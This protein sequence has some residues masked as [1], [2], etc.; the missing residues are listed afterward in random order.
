MDVLNKVISNKNKLADKMVRNMNVEIA[1]LG[2]CA[3]SITFGNK[4]DEGIHQQIH[5]FLHIFRLKRVKGVIEYAPSYTSIAIFYNPAIV[6][7]SQLV[8]E[9]YSSYHSAL[10]TTEIQSIVYRIPVYYGGKTGPDLRFVAE[11]HNINEQEVINLHA[12]KE[13]LIHMI[14]FVPGFPYLGGLSKKIAT[15]RLEKPRPKIAA[16]SVGIGGSQTGIYPSEV[17]SGW[18]IIGITPLSLFDL[19]NENPSLLSAGN[20]VSFQPIEYE[21]FLTIQAQVA[22]K[23]YDIKTYKRER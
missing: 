2:D 1:P 17:P 19:E 22:D 8:N 10:R 16:G 3:I 6:T 4:I 23:K 14:G 18:R 9:V 20:Y 12:N 21:E 13:Y 11:Y 7:Y 15:P 5:Q